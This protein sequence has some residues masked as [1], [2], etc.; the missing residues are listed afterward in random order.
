MFAHTVRKKKCFTWEGER[1]PLKLVYF[2]TSPITDV[3]IGQEMKTQMNLNRKMIIALGA[4]ATFATAANADFTGAVFQHVQYVNVVDGFSA[5]DF[6]GTVIDLWAESDDAADILLNVYGYHDANFGTAYYQSF[7][8]G[9]WLPNNQGPPFETPALQY[10]D[11]Y[12][13]IGGYNGGSQPNNDGTGL[14]PNFGGTD[15]DGPAEGSGWYN[16]NPAK[17]NGQAVATS[18]TDSGLGVFIGRFSLNDGGA[19][20]SMEGTFGEFTWNQGLGT[21][22]H[23]GGFSVIPAPGAVALLGLAGLAGRR[24]RN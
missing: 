7:T 14:D 24:R 3:V 13:S 6:D 9:T 23:Q 21:P 20:F 2:K 10:A 17:Y 1:T 4:S 5:P 11:S 22:G 15:A 16:S 8:G 19:G 12:V 18:H